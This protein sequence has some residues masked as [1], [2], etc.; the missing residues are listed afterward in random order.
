MKHIENLT[1]ATKRKDAEINGDDEDDE[2][3]QPRYNMRR[4]IGH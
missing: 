1:T 2:A 4:R 3:L